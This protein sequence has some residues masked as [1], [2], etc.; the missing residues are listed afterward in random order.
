MEV[1]ALMAGLVVVVL[2]IVH[3]EIFMSI[4]KFPP[5]C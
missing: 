2:L 1:G 3:T 4:A 5:L